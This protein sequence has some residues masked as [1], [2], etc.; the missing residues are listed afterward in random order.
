MKLLKNIFCSIL[1]ACFAISMLTSCSSKYDD[2]KESIKSNEEY[3]EKSQ[4]LYISESVRLGINDDDDTVTLWVN[5]DMYEVNMGRFSFYID[6]ADTDDGRM[7]WALSNS[8]YSSYL[9]ASY[10]YY[11]SGNLKSEHITKS[12]DSLVVHDFKFHINYE[13]EESDDYE[14]KQ[15]YAK[16]AAVSLHIGLEAFSDY[17]AESNLEYT[18]E[19]Y[20]F[21]NYK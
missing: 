21:K 18:L 8:N 1:I 11:A 6:I 12:T 16:L 4:T 3:S 7:E 10:G 13:Y 17:L 15:E 5:I 19:D 2:L 20:G 9:K 14:K